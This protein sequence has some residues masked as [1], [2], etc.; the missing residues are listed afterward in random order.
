MQMEI[1]KWDSNLGD[2]VIEDV[3][4]TQ[5]LYIIKSHKHVIKE[6]Q[7]GVLISTAVS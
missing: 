7:T 1:L 6:A 3:L 5:T 4:K 2:Q